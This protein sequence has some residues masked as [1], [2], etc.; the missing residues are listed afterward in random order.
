MKGRYRFQ[1]P[2]GAADLAGLFSFSFFSC[3]RWT[4]GVRS[5]NAATN[6][7]ERRVIGPSFFFGVGIASTLRVTLRTHAEETNPRREFNHVPDRD[8]RPRPARRRLAGIRPRTR[9][10]GAARFP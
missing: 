10:Q 6:N 8:L 4:A 9:L 3:A 7:R 5:T 2:A 1:V